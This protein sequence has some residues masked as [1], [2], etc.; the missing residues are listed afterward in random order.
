[1][2]RLR[3]AR[4][5]SLVL[6]GF[7]LAQAVSAQQQPLTRHFVTG[8]EE[9]Y[10][11]TLEIKSESHSVMSETRADKTYVSPRDLS[12][13]ARLRC[14]VWRKI[15][16]VEPSGSAQIEEKVTPAGPS[17]AEAVS[18]GS[19]TD[20]AMRNALVDFCVE[21]SKGSTIR[22]S[23]SPFGL[24]TDATSLAI[25]PLGESAPALL[26]PWLRRAS[27][28]S[29]ILPDLPLAIGASRQNALQPSNVQ[30]QN[31]HGSETT[32]WLE[33]QG[34]TPAATL[35]VVQQLSWK[36]SPDAAKSGQSHART[37]RDEIFFA[38]SLTTLSLVD[39]SVLRASRTA[40]RTT[41]HPIDPVPGLPNPPDFSSKLTLTVA[42]ERQ[43]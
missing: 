19:A 24:Q 35:H 33:A 31:A 36:S 3:Q 22:Y 30:L 15:L 16:S 7:A 8:T 43:P 5:L 42:I 12:A 11:V 2:N 27:R 4:L 37:A 38:D 1:M 13:A 23:E 6:S 21:W 39:S 25:V 26:A 41:T 34:D 9:R 29:V 18:R 10:Q 32:Q 40:S 20:P 14:I 17:C 28:A